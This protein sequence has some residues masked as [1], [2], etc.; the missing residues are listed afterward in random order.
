[1]QDI[2]KSYWTYPV[3]D[4]R[5]ALRIPIHTVNQIQRHTIA[6]AVFKAAIQTFRIFVVMYIKYEVAGI[7]S[8]LQCQQEDGDI[9][10]IHKIQCQR[11]VLHCL[12]FLIHPDLI[13]DNEY[14]FIINEIHNGSFLFDCGR[15]YFS[16]FYIHFITCFSFYRIIPRI[17]YVPVQKPLESEL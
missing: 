11:I 15:K 6:V 5:G 13:L 4:G 7:N 16:Y 14:K 17:P 9:I 2:G 3:T 12:T 1:M 8:I 10:F